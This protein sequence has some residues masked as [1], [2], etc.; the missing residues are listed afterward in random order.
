MS[1]EFKVLSH[2]CLLIKS[3][4]TSIVIDPWL[5]GSCYWRSWWNFP[6]AKFDVQEIEEVDAVLISHVHWDH[7]HGPTLRKYF[8][9][10]RII[11]PDEPGLRSRGDL[12][13]MGFKTQPVK[14]GVTIQLGSFKITLYQFGLI[15][16]DAAIVIE[17]NGK[18]ILN[19]NDAKIA[20]FPLRHILKR[21]GNID[22][23]FRSHSSANQRICYELEGGDYAQYDDPEHYFRSFA[24]FMSAVKPKYAIPFASNH[25]HLHKEV[26][27]FNSYISDPI[28][29]EK[30][31]E[32]ANHKYNWE[33]KVMMPGSKWTEESGFH[34]EDPIEFKNKDIAL[35]EYQNDVK[36]KL[37]A[38]YEKEGKIEIDEPTWDKFKLMTQ[39][40]FYRKGLGKFMVSVTKPDG[41]G[42][43]KLIHKN[44]IQDIS[45]TMKSESGIPLI[46]IPALV[47][48]DSVKKNMFE[49]AGI[50]KRCRFLAS[51]EKDMKRLVRIVNHI[52]QKERLPLALTARQFM[53]FPIAYVRRWRELFVYLEAFY[54]RYL[55][56]LPLYI[57][58]E[59]ILNKT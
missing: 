36:D 31:I 8:N 11:I 39:T 6:K 35:E 30:Y 34:L 28:E 4:D 43:S 58:E 3:D 18:V 24:L 56:K 20:G 47:F 23:A 19:A 54:L 41:S 32:Q 14:H 29:L 37:E 42:G 5:L 27:K 21:H 2:A 1:L 10:K 45:F 25:C 16:T 49:H 40:P 9:D 13:Q 26:F 52:E 22:F 12:Q 15:F 55:K 59:K 48:R 7:W 50:S 51:N 33:L 57:V 44:Q 53:R 38:T 46:I 17:A